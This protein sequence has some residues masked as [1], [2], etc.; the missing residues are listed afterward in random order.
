MGVDIAFYMMGLLVVMVLLGFHIGIALGLCSALGV[1]LMM[2]SIDVAF[3]IVV[4]PQQV[5]W[6]SAPTS[7]DRS[8]S[9]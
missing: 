3:S 8:R 7:G 4:S 1:Y 6:S 9:R 5:E 2:G